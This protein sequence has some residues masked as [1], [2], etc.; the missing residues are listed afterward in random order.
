MEIHKKEGGVSSGFFGKRLGCKNRNVCHGW[1]SANESESNRR[2][3]ARTRET[4]ASR[5][6]ASA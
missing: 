6:I 5:M 2:L 3:L 4:D 1:K